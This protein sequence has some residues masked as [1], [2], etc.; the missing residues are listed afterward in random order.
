MLFE[1]PL[2]QT[3]G[4]VRSLLKLI[5]LDWE[6]PDFSTLGRRQKKLPVVVL[7]QGLSYVFPI[8]LQRLSH[9][10][11]SQFWRA[12]VAAGSVWAWS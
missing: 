10:P 3:M 2:R 4:L 7:Y 5:D 6:V 9:C 1:M 12:M 8:D 11:P